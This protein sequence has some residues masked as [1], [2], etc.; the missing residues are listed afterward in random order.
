MTSSPSALEPFSLSFANHHPCVREAGYRRFLRLPARHPLDGPLAENAG[1][2][3][4]W[5]AAHARPWLCA[6]EVSLTAGPAA[7]LIDGEPFGTAALA[8]RFAG[9]SRGALAA[10]S[11]GPEAE[12]EAAARWKA[13]EPDRYFFL[14]CYASAATDALLAEA[15]QRLGAGEFFC[16]GYRGWPIEESV[17]LLALLERKITLPGPLR[18]LP[19]GM[20]QP[21]KSQIALLA[22]K[23]APS[24]QPSP[25]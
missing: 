3:R 6:A 16:P 1:W 4:A 15:R 25:P 2:A 18:A 5:F 13:D 21:K 20:L 7:L 17:R 8:A 24:S 22:L 19:S 12:A 10:V 23:P 14:E 11:A 9:A